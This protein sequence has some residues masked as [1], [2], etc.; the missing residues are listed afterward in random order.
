MDFHLPSIIHA[1]RTISRFRR[2]RCLDHHDHQPGTYPS[3]NSP[4]PL[5][6]NRSVDG[7]GRAADRTIVSFGN[8]A[9]SLKCDRLLVHRAGGRYA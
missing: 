1:Q 4:D 9:V 3:A 8:A 2:V 6:T 5:A 7:C